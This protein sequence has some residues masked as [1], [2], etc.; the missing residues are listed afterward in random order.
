MITEPT[1]QSLY[2]IDQYAGVLKKYEDL[3]KITFFK[4]FTEVKAFR[5]WRSV[6]EENQ[7]KN[8]KI[9]VENKIRNVYRNVYTDLTFLF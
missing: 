5:K 9:K 2:S 8:I 7:S 1:E 4:Y 3:N 6:V